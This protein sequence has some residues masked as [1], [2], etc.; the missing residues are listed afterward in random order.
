MDSWA[1][2]PCMNKEFEMDYRL[3]VDTGNPEIVSM[4]MVDDDLDLC[5]THDDHVEHPAT[6]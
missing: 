5:F 6:A 1:I 4:L 2:P 3:R